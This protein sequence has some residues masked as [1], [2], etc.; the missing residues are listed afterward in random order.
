MHKGYLIDESIFVYLNRQNYK[1][2]SQ[3]VAF[4]EDARLSK[5]EGQRRHVLY[6]PYC[7]RIRLGA[8]RLFHALTYMK[9]FLKY[10]GVALMPLEKAE[11]RS[12]IAQ[13]Y[14]AKYLKSSWTEKFARWFFPKTLIN[15]FIYA[16]ENKSNYLQE[17]EKRKILPHEVIPLEICEIAMIAKRSKLD[18][19]SFNE[20]YKYLTML[21]G[22]SAS[23]ITYL[24]PDDLLKEYVGERSK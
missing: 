9:K 23:Y 17:K 18:I 10:K 11:M 4:L 14:V 19:L 6:M 21:P 1:Y 5:Q 20:D 16:N 2:H 8:F 15:L 7:S 12:Q 13:T 3:L 24:N 22:K